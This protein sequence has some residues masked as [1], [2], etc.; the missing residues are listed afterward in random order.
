MSTPKRGRCQARC[1]GKGRRSLRERLRAFG[2]IECR[3]VYSR[4]DRVRFHL[5]RRTWRASREREAATVARR[6]FGRAQPR[7]CAGA[8][9]SSR[10]LMPSAICA[11]LSARCV[12]QAVWVIASGSPTGH[13]TRS[14]CCGVVFLAFPLRSV[15]EFP[16]QGDAVMHIRMW[17]FSL[18]IGQGEGP[19]TNIS[20]IM[21]AI[22]GADER[23]QRLIYHDWQLSS[24]AKRPTFRREVEAKKSACRREAS[25]D[26]GGTFWGAGWVVKEIG[27]SCAMLGQSAGGE[28]RAPE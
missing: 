26:P 28:G 27:R 18:E 1:A 15:R 16:S 9:V 12:Q 14:R 23:K 4:A 2:G 13:N 21:S 24:I 6:T 10:F 17:L 11:R 19:P 8:G 25:G 20:V 3:V 7:L 22:R 5:L